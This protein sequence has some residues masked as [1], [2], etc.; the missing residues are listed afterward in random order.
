MKVS[1]NIRLQL[2]VQKIV[3]IVLLLSVIGLI[4]SL[5]QKYPLQYDWTAGQRNTISQNSIDL[6]KSM[7]YAVTL[8]V[9]IQEDVVLRSAVEEILRRYQREKA[10]FNFKIIN[11]DIDIELAQLDKVTRYGQA[12]IKYQ[13]RSEVISSL[14]ENVLSSALQRLSYN[15]ERS[16][17]FI[18]GHAERNPSNN[19]NTGYSQFTSQLISK[20]IKSSQHHLLKSALADDTDILVIAAPSKPF[21]DGELQHIKEHIERGGNLLWLMDPDTNIHNLTEIAELLK[22]KF[23]DGIIVDN[24]INLRKTLGIQHPA[25]IPV[26]DY[27]PHAI[28]KNISYN[29]L[30]PIS[31]GIIVEDN[32]EWQNTIIAQSLTQSW[33]ESQDLVDGIIFDSNSGDVAGPL[34]IVVALERPVIDNNQYPNK[35]SQR[36]IISGDSDF[37]SNSYLGVGANLT[38]GL[39]IIDWLGGDDDLIT[40]EIKN[41]PDT[42]LL[43][44]DTEILIIGFGFFILLPAGLLFTGLFIWHRRR[45]R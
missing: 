33:S 10:N 17:V 22:I 37:L 41:A 14:S 35:A 23:I 31:R 42:K 12:V 20:G 13:G 18:E 11:P 1:K 16:L 28:T 32:N 45:K 29:T 7:D 43:L 25:M 4:A 39:N 44:D 9:Y 40:I 19:E 36:I 8:N 24:N 30:F 2:Q 26:L 34:A 38:L 6:L 5:S 27:H 3:F 21:L 15:S